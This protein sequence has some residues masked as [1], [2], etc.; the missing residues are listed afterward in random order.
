MKRI[1]F[2]VLAAMVFSAGF[3]GGAI[4]GRFFNGET[5]I[6]QESDT[7]T[8]S[9]FQV[10]DSEGRPRIMLTT[11]DDDQGRP[12]VMFTNEAGELAHVYGLT[13]TGEPTFSMIDS[14][15]VTRLGAAVTDAEGP[16]IFID[17]EKEQTIWSAP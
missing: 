7:I 1:H 14:H 2:A 16:A 9:S 3:I 13:E 4:E 17:N 12:L 5:S 10:L 6:A 11:S 15:G 8:A